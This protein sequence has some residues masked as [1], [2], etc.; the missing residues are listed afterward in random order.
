MQDERHR[1]P[2]MGEFILTDRYDRDGG[3]TATLADG[4]DE[5]FALLRGGAFNGSAQDAKTT[6]QRL[7]SFV[8]AHGRT[9]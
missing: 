3:A 2:W 5:E 7:Y 6:A 9:S 8:V 4:I 1:R